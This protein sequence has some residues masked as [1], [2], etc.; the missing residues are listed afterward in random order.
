MI[1]TTARRPASFLIIAAVLVC[2]SACAVSM[3]TPGTRPGPL[4]TIPSSP[5]PPTAQAKS[6]VTSAIQNT[7]STTAAFSVELQNH[8]WVPGEPTVAKG[9]IDFRTDKG[10]IQ[11]AT[12]MNKM[13][14]VF[15][16]NVM[17][18]L[19]P[20]T[21]KWRLPAGRPWVVVDLT[22]ADIIPLA[23]PQFVFQLDQTN[24][25]L[26]L[27]IISRGIMSAAPD[28]VG[29]S[30]TSTHYVVNISLVTALA[31]SQSSPVVA[32]NLESDM[33][34]LPNGPSLT[35]VVALDGANHVSQIVIERPGT[36]LG[37]TDEV[38]DDFGQAVHT[39]YPRTD[40]TV[41]VE[42]ITNDNDADDT[43]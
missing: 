4:P 27:T 22:R 38:L 11:L 43:K 19:P 17:D 23:L 15:D 40:Q 26:L 10:K 39:S 2:T 7:L 37:I 30:P 35:A 9:S 33:N 21:L 6:A 32:A 16:S 28:G 1:A 18:V 5:Q 42:A 3:P 34:A 41:S 25:A 13:S 8:F 12:G 14:I 29:N 31:A 20:S 24:P 36:F